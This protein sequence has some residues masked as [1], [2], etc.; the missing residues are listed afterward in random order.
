VPDLSGQVALVTGAS[1]GIGRHLVEGLAARGASVAGLARGAERLQTAMAEVAEATGARTLAVAA[2]VTD[3]SSVDAAVG[4][5]V[6]ELGR[7]DLLVNNAGVIDE[8]EVPLW[9][10]DP[11]QW[12]DVVTTHVKGGFLLCR[13]VVPW[14]VLRNRG[15]VINIAS[16]MSVRARP[17]YSAYS[18]SKTGL[19]RMTEALAGALEGSDVRAFDVAPGVV[20]TEMTRAMPMWKGFTDW[21]PPEKVVEIVTAI[22]AGELDQWSGRFLRAGKD[23][24][25]A[26][27][28]TTP[29][30]AARQ[31]RLRRYRDDDPVA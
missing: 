23:D 15:R 13:T 6:G 20:E 27:R 5:V 22:A 9:E 4:E 1:T 17:E 8:L 3:R 16:G 26:L 7:I 2:N 31:L 11:D 25:A 10:A 29:T 19:M 21:T 18:V 24:V 28:A 12:W 30:D 14:M